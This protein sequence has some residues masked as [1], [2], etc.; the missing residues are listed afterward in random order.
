MTVLIKELLDYATAGKREINIAPLDLGKVLKETLETLSAEVEEKKAE[1]LVAPLP[2][3]A[4]QP[5]LARVLFQNLIDNALKYCERQP[6]IHVSAVRQGSK[7][8]FSVRDNGIGIPAG[9]LKR[10]FIMF[11]KSPTQQRYPGSGIGLATSQ[12]IVMNYGGRIWVKSQPGEGS[13]FFFTLPAF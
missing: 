1:V 8:L 9:D 5:E 2:T 3:L 13:T 6:R 4:I 12:K 7:W 10:I 11:E